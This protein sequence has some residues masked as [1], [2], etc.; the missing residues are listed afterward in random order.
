MMLNKI[1]R[2]NHINLIIVVL[3]IIVAL[4]SIY[5][6]KSIE[7]LENN[8]DNAVNYN[9]LI[10]QQNDKDNIYVSL[11]IVDIPYEIAERKVNYAYEKYYILYDKN[12]YM[13]VA[14]LSDKTFK[15]I[16]EEYQKNSANFSYTLVGYIYKIPND[17]KKI[18]IDVYNT[19]NDGN[20]INNSNYYKYFGSTYIDDTYTKYT[21]RIAIYHIIMII[22]VLVGSICLINWCIYMINTR[23]TFKKLSF[24]QLDD[25]LSKSSK[26]YSNVGI[27]LTDNYLIST[28]R[29]LHVFSYHDIIWVY[30]GNNGKPLTKDKIHINIF[31]KGKIKYLTKSVYNG[32]SSIFSEIIDE[33]LNKNENVMVG[34]TYENMKNYKTV[35]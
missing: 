17:L 14:K 8:A 31:A 19:D 22:S 18:I 13:Y 6:F 9:E 7:K 2:K 26:S 4:F 3:C 5:R 15:K 24:T 16:K 23:K 30:L 32:E 20:E 29:G 35:N 1:L 33:I 28:Y 34:Y 25:E 10:T 27:Y 11:E 12:N 21:S